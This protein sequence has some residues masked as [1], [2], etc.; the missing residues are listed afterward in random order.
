MLQ[1]HDEAQAGIHI[2]KE[3]AA[4]AAGWVAIV[5]YVSTVGRAA[6]RKPWAIP[7]MPLKNEPLVWRGVRLGNTTRCH[8]TAEDPL[9]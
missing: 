6:F 2:S 1:G 8:A 5:P 3:A 4:H 7:A 9:K